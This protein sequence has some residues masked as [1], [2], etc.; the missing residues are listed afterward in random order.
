MTNFCQLLALFKAAATGMAAKIS[1][2]PMATQARVKNRVIGFMCRRLPDG[3]VATEP[4]LPRV[5]SSRLGNYSR[6]GRREAP[7]R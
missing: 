6:P 5:E 3:S 7:L 1:A 4:R 2:A